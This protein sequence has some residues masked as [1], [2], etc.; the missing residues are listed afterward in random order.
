MEIRRAMP[1]DEKVLAYIQCRS[2]QDAFADILSKEELEK[3]TDREKLEQMYRNILQSTRCSIAIG[4]VHGNPHAI[5]AWGENRCDM[6]DTVG[7][8][9]CIHSMQDGW[10]K[11]YGSEMM[12]YVL[13]ELRKARY[14]SVILW[15]FEKNTRARHFY[16]KI[17]FELTEQKTICNG[18]TEVMYQKEL[19]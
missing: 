18:V 14:K 13:G 11:G 6:E 2:W 12:Q 19:E 1:G 17:G 4:F 5:A 7:E 9:I 3:S 16:E 10:R 8:L 15:V